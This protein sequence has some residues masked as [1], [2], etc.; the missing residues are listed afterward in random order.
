MNS[1]LSLN[2]INLRGLTDDELLMI[3]GGSWLSKIAAVAEIVGG[4]AAVVVGVGMIATPEPAMTKVG[5]YA[6][7]VGGWSAIVHGAASF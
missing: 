5:G 1:A 7:I 6:T 2:S 4:V 3:D